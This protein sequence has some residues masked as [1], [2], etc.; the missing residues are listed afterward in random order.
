MTDWERI[1]RADGAEMIQGNGEFR[2]GKGARVTDWQ[3]SAAAAWQE[4]CRMMRHKFQPTHRISYGPRRIA[5]QV[6]DGA[7]YR[8]G[9]WDATASADWEI[10]TF[11]TLTFMGIKVRATIRPIKPEAR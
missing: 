2:A 11:G 8:R 10:D 1:A 4:Y 7:C 6:V 9:E 5:V 3:P